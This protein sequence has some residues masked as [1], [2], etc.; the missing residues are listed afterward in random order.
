[1]ISCSYFALPMTLQWMETEEKNVR[2][3]EGTSGESQNNC[4]A[5]IVL[6]L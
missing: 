5:L 1:M 2:G 3:E 6:I 4:D